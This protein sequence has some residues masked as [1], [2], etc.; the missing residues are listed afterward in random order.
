MD[1]HKHWTLGA[2]QA[3][4]AAA[5][6][7]E[8]TAADYDEMAMREAKHI[9]SQFPSLRAQQIHAE[10]V[11]RDKAQLLRGQAGHIRKLRV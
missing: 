7:L 5:K 11:L 9:K 4:E 6:L 2:A 10:A 3:L 1:A 8:A